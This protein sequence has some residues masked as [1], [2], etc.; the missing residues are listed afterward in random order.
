MVL[1][2]PPT[3]CS[4]TAPALQEKGP[5]LKPGTETL[6]PSLCPQHNC[7]RGR[8]GKFRIPLKPTPRQRQAWTQESTVFLLFILHPKKTPG[9]PHHVVGTLGPRFGKRGLR[10]PKYLPGSNYRMNDSSDPSF[11]RDML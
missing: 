11:A 9:N 3:Q 1:A 8:R 6:R 10:F 5:D 7:P 4:C 2:V